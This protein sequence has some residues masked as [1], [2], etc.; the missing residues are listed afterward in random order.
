MLDI[1][2]HLVYIAKQAKLARDHNT[3]RFVHI[4]PNYTLA[5]DIQEKL[6]S[7][8]VGVSI[9]SIDNDWLMI[10]SWEYI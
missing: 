3:N 4:V 7:S 6:E 10:I 1:H 9:G 5:L 8:G 2:Q